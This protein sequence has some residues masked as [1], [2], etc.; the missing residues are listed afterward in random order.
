MIFEEM[1]FVIMVKKIKYPLGLSSH[2]S[3]KKLEKGNSIFDVDSA[4]FFSPPAA[5]ST[6]EVEGR[7]GIDAQCTYPRL[8]V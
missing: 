2:N 1:S 4:S 8:L 3:K 6:S 7:R 5:V